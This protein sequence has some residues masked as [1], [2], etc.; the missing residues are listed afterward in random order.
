MYFLFQTVTFQVSLITDNNNTYV[1]ILYQ[2]RAFTWDLP[3]YSQPNYPARVG[4][5]IQSNGA[6]MSKEYP[7]SYLDLSASD[8]AS[9]KPLLEKIDG[10]S[11]TTSQLSGTSW[12]NLNM[13]M[14]SKGKLVFKLTDNDANFKHHGIMC[15]DWIYIDIADTLS[16]VDATDATKCPCVKSQMVEL[17]F[18]VITN[19]RIP[20]GYTCYITATA[21]SGSNPRSRRCCY[22]NQGQLITDHVVVNGMNTY[23]R[24]SG[25][26]Q[27]EADQIYDSC[28]K[29][30]YS[31]Y[32][33]TSLCD[34][35]LAQ[36]PV[37]SC[38]SFESSSIGRY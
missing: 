27:D 11:E 6:M 34:Q 3:A 9:I 32:V 26:V 31:H 17:F 16:Q 5:A 4:Y 8:V 36:R 38:S 19:S 15:R 35:F 28:C 23:Q 25:S 29:S 30:M 2:D 21:A 12:N 37:S 1:V 33:K 18:A 10:V 13:K 22:D 20:S 7:Y 14:P 24:H